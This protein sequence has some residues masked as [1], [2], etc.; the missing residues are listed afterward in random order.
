MNRR[1]AVISILFALFVVLMLT[2]TAVAAQDA[3]PFSPPEPMTFTNPWT[4]VY[5]NNPD[6]AGLPVVSQSESQVGRYW[7]FNSPI[8]GIVN[9]DNFSIRYGSSQPFNAARYEFHVYADDGVR[10]YID[11]AL[12]LD[13]WINN[14]A[15][16]DVFALD[17]TAGDH[18]ITVEYR[19]ITRVATLAIA[20]FEEGIFTG[21]VRAADGVTPIAGAQVE[22]FGFNYYGSYV[23]SVGT[24]TTAADGTYALRAL[25]GRYRVVAR[26]PGYSEEFWRE[27][28][29]V[30]GSTELLMGT[31]ETTPN[32]NFTLTPDALISGRVTELD[33]TTP[34]LGALITVFRY[35]VSGAY[36]DIIRTA[37]TAADGTYAIGV[38]PGNYRV[39]ASS[40]RHEPE[41]FNERRTLDLADTLTLTVGGAAPGTNFTLARYGTI[42]GRVLAENGASPINGARVTFSPANSSGG[43]ETSVANIFTPANGRFEVSLPPGEYRFGVTLARGASA[44]SY[45]DGQP[46]FQLSDTVTVQNGDVYTNMNIVLGGT[47]DRTSVFFGDVMLEGRPAEPHPR[48]AVTMRV[49]VTPLTGGARLDRTLSSDPLSTFRLPYLA[50]GQYRIW[51]KGA[52]SLAFTQTITVIAG[53]N[54]I[55]LLLLREGD[56]SGDNVINITDFSILAGTFGKRSTDVGYDARADFNGDNVINIGDFSLLAGNF[57]ASGAALVP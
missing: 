54:N 55:P 39:S 28:P 21:T 35:D 18:V 20:Y 46:T 1:A 45:F 31:A 57:G 6:L 7:G 9:A 52:T 32:I 50:P 14:S 30:T 36:Q 43:L 13:S 41:Y 19:E 56:A 44:S 22:A 24:T 29:T 47:A 23:G 12:V 4:A 25:P 53:G 26:V 37:S 33:D 27:Q 17:M 40:P 5:Y 3:S 51:V 42:S 34:I 11:G 10:L 49:V 2:V 8:P 48:H 15:N 16:G 38:P